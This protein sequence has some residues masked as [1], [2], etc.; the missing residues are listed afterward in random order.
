MIFVKDD[1]P[2]K[3]IKVNFLPSDVECLFI[4]LNVRKVKWLIVDCYHLPSQNDDY[5]FC[6]LSKVLDSLNTNYEKFLL[7]EDFNSE[8]HEIEISFLNNHKAKNI[9][10]EKMFQKCFKLL[11]L[12]SF[13][14]QQP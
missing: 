8:D 11:M 10:K 2:L 4:E 3:E 13:Y 1:I 7:I 9:V 5:Y 14:Y 12:G 6:S